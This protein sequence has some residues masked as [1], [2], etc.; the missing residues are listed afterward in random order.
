MIF[1]LLKKRALC[2]QVFVG[3]LLVVGTLSKKIP[4]PSVLC[5]DCDG[6]PPCEKTTICGDSGLV[7]FETLIAGTG[8][9]LRSCFEEGGADCF[10]KGYKSED[11]CF[12]E[13]EPGD[14]SAAYKDCLYGR[15]VGWGGTA[16]SFQNRKPG[17]KLCFCKTDKCNMG[18]LPKS[19]DRNGNGSKS[20]GG[21][22]QSRK[23]IFAI[24]TTAGVYSWI[25]FPSSSF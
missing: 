3:L 2:V 9:I 17:D 5:Y 10:E 21:N 7:C 4:N 20:E 6:P 22:L 18:L 14:I 12:T 24:L 19:P 15:S 8:E 23:W 25:L 1:L 11:G 16:R 13:P